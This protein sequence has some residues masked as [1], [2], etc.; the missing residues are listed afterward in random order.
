MAIRQRTSS[1]GQISLNSINKEADNDSPAFEFI[2]NTIA[3]TKL[4]ASKEI[5]PLFS[6]WQYLTNIKL[7]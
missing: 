4:K 1:L 2:L 7:A 6:Q 3:V 5:L